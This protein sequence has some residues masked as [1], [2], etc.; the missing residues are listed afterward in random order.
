MARSTSAIRLRDPKPE[1]LN[2]DALDQHA[3][4]RAL[5]SVGAVI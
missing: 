5:A 1:K 3:I 4:E 2:G